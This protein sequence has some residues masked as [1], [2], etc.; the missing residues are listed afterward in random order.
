MAHDDTAVSG[1]NDKAH[2]FAQVLYGVLFFNIFSRQ[3]LYDLVRAERLIKWK[4]F[5]RGDTIFS[6]GSFDQHFYIVIQGKV[7]LRSK[8]SEGREVVRATKQPGDVFGEQVVCDPESPRRTSACV[9][10][11]EP[12]V[13]CEIDATLVMTVGD[14]LKVKFLKKFLDLVVEQIQD[15]AVRLQYYQDVLHYADECNL[16]ERDEYFAYTVET[17]VSEK[18]RL[19]QFVKYTDF[20]ITR[21]IPPE[22]GC[23]LLERLLFQAAQEIEA[24][25]SAPVPPS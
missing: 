17:A 7:D 9:S 8:N 6:Q 1:G 5:N 4:K 16:A 14:A 21:K 12:A 24:D 10:G 20:L 3:E 11:S 15:P 19:T 13:I 2:T 23:T 22:N 18:N 25:A